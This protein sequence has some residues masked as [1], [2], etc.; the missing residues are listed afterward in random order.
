MLTLKQTKMK[1]KFL[2]VLNVCFLFSSFYFILKNY[3]YQHL[4]LFKMDAYM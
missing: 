4:F 3:H 1:F 2:L